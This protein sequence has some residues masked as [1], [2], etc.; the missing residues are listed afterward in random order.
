SS[1]GDLCEGFL[2]MAWRTC[3]HHHPGPLPGVGQG[4][5]TSHTAPGA[6]DQHHLVF[7]P[8]RL[9]P[10]LLLL[11]GNPPAAVGPREARQLGSDISA[12]YVARRTVA[13]VGLPPAQP[14]RRL[15]SIA[16]SAPAPL[17]LRGDRK[18][19]NE[20]DHFAPGVG[21]EFPL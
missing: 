5:G 14:V 19:A 11:F 20:V 7:E 16:D 10:L 18:T 3:G 12:W 1:R 21:K 9:F 17:L 6:G 13:P 15:A 4:D 8:H 2:A